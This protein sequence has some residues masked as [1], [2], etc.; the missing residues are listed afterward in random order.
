VLNKHRFKLINI[1]VAIVAIIVIMFLV[2]NA[3]VNL[4]TSF[5]FN[6]LAPGF[7]F[8]LTWFLEFISNPITFIRDGRHM[9]RR[10][11]I[12]RTL[13][14]EFD[15]LQG[16]GIEYSDELSTELFVPSNADIVLTY[17]FFIVIAAVIVM[18]VIKLLRNEKYQHLAPAKGINKI[19]EKITGKKVIPEVSIKHPIRELYRKYLLF[20]KDKGIDVEKFTTSMDIEKK[21]ATKFK[22]TETNEMREIYIKIRYGEK[23]FNRHELKKIKELLG[24]LKKSNP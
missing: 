2:S 5:Y 9:S 4:L 18:I 8:A 17:V 3:S 21:S 7:L 6:A 14:Y 23:D 16:L 12:A 10:G 19:R 13:E 11:P 15:G 22:N 24:D 20:C 1:S